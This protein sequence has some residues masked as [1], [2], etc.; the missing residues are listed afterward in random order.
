[1]RERWGKAR[2]MTQ[3]LYAHTNKIKNFF[4]TSIKTTYWVRLN[5]EAMRI[6]LL[7]QT[8]RMCKHIK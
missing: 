7:S 1:M 2:E 6:Q 5:A 3:T 4:K 8:L